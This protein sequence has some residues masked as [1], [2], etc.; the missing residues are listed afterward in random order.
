MK[1]QVMIFSVTLFITV[2]L[3]YGFL[4]SRTRETIPGAVSTELP[5]RCEII[6]FDRS[7]QPVY[8]IALACPRMDMIRLWPLPVQQPW[9]EDKWE[10]PPGNYEMGINYRLRRKETFNC[11]YPF[12]HF[13][14]SLP[15]FIIR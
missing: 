13:R 4:V 11:G 2:N 6:Q 9:F 7:L 1:R 12:M 8:T 14:G 3:A 5:G 10:K 15:L